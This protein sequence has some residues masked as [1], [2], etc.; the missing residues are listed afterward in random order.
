VCIAVLLTAD[1]ILVAVCEVVI[2]PPVATD[3]V[4]TQARDLKAADH[5]VRVEIEQDAKACTCISNAFK[6]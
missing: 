3:L 4:V 5:N 1:I 2:A 6:Y